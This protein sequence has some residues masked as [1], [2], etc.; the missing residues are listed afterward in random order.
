MFKLNLKIALRNLW[1]NRIISAINIGGLSV[2][3]AAFILVLMYVTFEKTFDSNLKQ[4][5]NIY[6]VG[7]NLGDIKT[8]YTS[9][10]LAKEIKEKFPEVVMVGRTKQFKLEFP[11][12]TVDKK[13]LYVNNATRMDYD[14]AVMF[15][16]NPDGGLNVPIDS[17]WGNMD[18]Y[19]PKQS[20]EY[21]FPGKESVKDQLVRAGSSVDGQQMPIKGSIDRDN[22]HSNLDFDVLIIAKNIGGEE[23]Y[24]Y[25]NYHTYIQVKPGTDIENLRQ[26]IDAL[27]KQVLVSQNEW[28]P[29]D[30]NAANKQLIFLDPLKNLHLKP[31]AGTNSNYKIVVTLS[32]LGLLILVI[33]CINFT[34]LSIAQANKRA[35]EVGVKKVMGA[36]RSGLTLQF[37]LEIFLQ[38]FMAVLIGLMLAEIALPLFNSLID[39]SLSVRQS[40]ASLAWQLPVIL[41]VITLVSGLYPAMILSGYRPAYVLKGNLQTSYKTVW[42]RNGLLVGQFAIAV[43]FIAGLFIVSAQLKYMRT[44]DA[45]FAPQQVVFVKNM[46]IFNDP[47]KFE[48]VREKIMKIPGV[49][50][51]TVA[52][53][54][55]GK[56]SGG[57]NTYTYNGAKE[58][59]TFVDVDYD[60]FETLEI[61]F[62]EGRSFSTKFAADTANSI[63]LNEAAANKF[64]LTSPIG[65]TIRGC[66]IAYNVVGVI[67][68]FKTDG[69]EKQVEP[70]VYTMKN[71]CG[72]YRLDIML[73]VD[74]GAMAATLAALKK[75]WPDINKLDGEDFRYQFMDEMYGSLF[76]KQQQLKSVFTAAAILTLFIALLGL[77]AVAAYATSNRSKEISIR[78][79]LGASNFQILKMLNTFFVRMVIIANLLAWPMAYLL[80]KQ[81]LNTFAYRMDLTIWPFLAAGFISIILT[82][83]TVSAQA[84]RSIRANPVDALKYE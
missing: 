54:I 68:D 8:N 60:Y 48:P 78:K 9:P 75:Q 5:D 17:E 28:K 42:L 24:G 63:I 49:R 27:Y 40:G 84:G 1:K 19:L 56:A 71:P 70:T 79:I 36:F 16:M 6:L 22:S 21:L 46:S 37:L 76:K 80:A 72:N 47:D 62:K 33:A 14:A 10:P 73:K 20:M 29:E 3:L 35:K 43:V 61:K 57:K 26:K 4:Y 25:N 58:I 69:F 51:V 81:W 77:F 53:N 41:M 7:R 39:G 31:T 44:E 34:N 18:T 67:K 12:N 59:L 82:L 50:S 15:E 64:G 74:Q 83:I 2:A 45:G 11:I 23:G 32:V 38:C 55:P 52:S 30:E 65:S 13:R 66:D